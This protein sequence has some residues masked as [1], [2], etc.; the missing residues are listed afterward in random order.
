MLAVEDE[1]DAEFDADG[2]A[3]P[4]CGPFQHHRVA[5]PI[6]VDYDRIQEVASDAA[7]SEEQQRLVERLQLG[8]DGAILGLGVDRLDYTKGI[9]ERLDGTRSDSDGAAGTTRP[10]DFR[11]DRR[12]SRSALESYQRD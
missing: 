12:T 2:D 8:L 9:P 6:G 7:L 3:N 4:V 10:A 5:V 1:L 11:S